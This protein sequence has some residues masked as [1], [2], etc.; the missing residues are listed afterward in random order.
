MIPLCGRAL[1]L[2]GVFC[3]ILLLRVL[4]RLV[5]AED[6]IQIRRAV[7][8]ELGVRAAG[9]VG[10]PRDGIVRPR[11]VEQRVHGGLVRGVGALVVRADKNAGVGDAVVAGNDALHQHEHRI[12]RACK[13]GGRGLT[14]VAVADVRA[15]R[16]AAVVPRRAEVFGQGGERRVR[17]R[18]VGLAALQR[19]RRVGVGLERQVDAVERVVER[20]HS[21]RVG[22][23][24]LRE[25]VVCGLIHRPAPFQRPRMTAS[26]PSASSMLEKRYLRSFCSRCAFSIGFSNFIRARCS[27]FSIWVLGRS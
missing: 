16:H 9:V 15:E 8:V 22:P 27:H 13:R 4:R 1:R 2:G 18:A 3:H 5:V 26:T 21:D 6:D 14:D 10:I 24:P 17:C 23:D 7:G 12:K 19:L 20:L 11:E 25:V